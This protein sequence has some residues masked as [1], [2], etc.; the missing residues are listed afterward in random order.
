[1]PYQPVLAAL[2]PKVETGLYLVWKKYQMFTKAADVFLEQIRR[3]I[4]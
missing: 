1:M 4:F 3:S 2:E